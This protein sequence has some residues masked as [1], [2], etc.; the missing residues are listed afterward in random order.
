MGFDRWMHGETD[1]HVS[2]WLEE[3]ICRSDGLGIFPAREQ[4]GD[5]AADGSDKTHDERPRTA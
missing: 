2:H 5:S 3:A 1:G 4:E